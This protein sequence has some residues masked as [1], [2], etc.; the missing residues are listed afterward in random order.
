MELLVVAGQS[1]AVYLFLVL[2]L[3][4]LAWA[5]MARLTPAEY[6][7]VA[8]LGSSVETALYHGSGSLL[9]GV[10]S[11]LTLM[12]TNRAVDRAMVRW[13]RVR[14]WLVGRPV[15]LVHDG[16]VLRSHLRRVWLTEADLRAAL[17]T[18]GYADLDGVRL[19]VLETTGDVG[20][21]PKEQEGG[22]E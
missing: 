3:S 18:K 9:S 21:V 13:P 19:A 6:L 8:L 5:H 14:R 2:G 12:L 4:R 15:V 7:M 22:G 16:R 17:R 20:V 1:L 10:V 11:A